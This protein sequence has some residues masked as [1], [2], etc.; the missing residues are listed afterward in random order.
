[1]RSDL[2]TMVRLA[3]HDCVGAA[4]CDG[5]I[6][7][8]DSSN[9]GLADLVA[10]LE[11]VYQ[12]NAF[13]ASG[14]SRADMWAILGLWAVQDGIDNSNDDCTDCNFTVPNIETSRGGAIS[15]TDGRVDCATAPYT[16]DMDPFPSAKSN[17]DDI[18]TYFN[19]TFGFSPLEV[20]ALM[21]AHTMGNA[22]I[23]NSG[24]NGPWVSGEFLYFNNKYYSNMVSSA[25][26]NWRLT[27]RECSSITDP[28]ID[29]SQCYDGQTTEWQYIG[30]GIGI[31]LPADMAI[32][33]NFTLDDEGKPECD[34]ANCDLAPTS[35]Y[36]DM[37][38]ASNDDFI[39]EFGSVFAKMISRGYDNLSVIS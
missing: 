24:Y 1:V 17:Y 4:G 7:V 5:C 20:T 19:T 35:S 8:N 29:T 12:D 37:F 27:Q 22:E 25:G 21:G 34:Y 33:Q 36:V 6:N 39:Q 11:T 31:N 15:Y 13:N 32:Y 9:N 16:T 26:V 2:A 3:F 10:N 18:M 14:V 28:T 23:T 38:A 30:G